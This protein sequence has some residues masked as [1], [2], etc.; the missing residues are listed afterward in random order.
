[1]FK[2]LRQ[3][4]DAV[5]ERDPAV[6]SRLEVVL[7]YPGFHALV[8]Y[9]VSRA[10]W[11]RKLYLLGRILSN[12]GRFFTG[13][14]IHPGAVIGQRFFIDHGS[15]VVI[16]E[17]SVIGD[18]VTLYHDVTLGGIAPAVD[19]GAQVNQKRHPTLG[20]DVIV[21]SGAQV[22]GPITLGKATRVGANSVVLKDVA[23]GVTVV[24]IPA[25]A[26]VPNTTL[27]PS[28]FDAYGTPTGERSDPM[29]Q[30]IDG[31]SKQIER[32]GA[33]LDEVESRTA[34]APRAVGAAGAEAGDL[35]EEERAS[36]N[37]N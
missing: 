14:E 2:K 5:F 17:T 34:G 10:C 28:R 19:S 1:M 30:V 6:R 37:E 25:K 29:A 27:R 20:D 16:G 21:G 9:R 36:C 8:F 18:N 4:I 11:V 13:I 23:P 26:V 15:G 7:C 24:G 3:D 35:I 32:L 12:L 31:L 22:L 33:R